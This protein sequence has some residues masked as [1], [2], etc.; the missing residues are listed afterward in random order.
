M[1][2][3]TKKIIGRSTNVAFPELEVDDIPARVD[4]GARLSSVWASAE[5]RDGI[6]RVVLLGAK[7]E[8]FNGKEFQFKEFEQVVVASSMGHIQKRYKVKLL[9]KIGG[10]KIRAQFTLADRSTQVYPVLIGR[11]VLQGKFIVDVKTGKV[12]HEAEKQRADSL[13][14]R[15]EDL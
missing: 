6:L 15:L 2:I 5:E 12:Q 7:H 11:N 3:P 14:S 9:V 13:Q 1:S 8:R 10:K 4:T